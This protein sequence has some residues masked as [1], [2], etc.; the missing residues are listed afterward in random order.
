[1]LRA[2]GSIEQL[3]I[4]TVALVGAD[5]EAMARAIAKAS[6][7][8][9]QAI[10]TY[11]A[12]GIIQ[13]DDDETLHRKVVDSMLPVIIEALDTRGDA[14]VTDDAS[15][16]T[17][18][19][20]REDVVFSGDLDQV[21]D[22]FGDQGW[23]DGLPVVP[24]TIDRVRRFLAHT[25]RDA[26]EVLGILLP[27]HREATVWNVAVNGVMAGCRPEYLPVLIAIAEGIADPVFHLQDAGSTPGWEP[28][29]TVSGPIVEE[30]EFNYRQ[31]AMRVGRQANSSIGRFLRLYMRNVAGFRIP[32]GVTDGAAIGTTFNV[33]L[34]ES[35]VVA[36]E[37]GWPST[38]EE[39]GYGKDES[40]V[41]LQSVRS[42]TPPIYSMGITPAEHMEA[43][44]EAA[45][46][47]L[48]TSVHRAYVCGKQYPTILMNPA[49]AE[50][51]VKA[52]VGRQ[53]I[54]EY[55]AEHCWIPVHVAET[56]GQRVGRSPNAPTCLESAQQVGIDPE[57]RDGELS[58][59]LFIDPEAILVVA[60]GN[61]GR[62]QSRM[63]FDNAP[64]GGR[65]I[66]R[67][68]S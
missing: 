46:G 40:V 28:L 62:N 45:T 43:L 15:V 63:Y 13:T 33:V 59:P 35:D 61:P 50:V 55:L 64:Q 5:F 2:C 47:S 58:L 67:I 25:D 52:G 57:M 12:P 30:L 8:P 21:M 17:P 11:P 56:W 18:R 54:R 38:R 29:I 51:F 4:P 9:R 60:G 6:P 24:P 68:G 48:R 37:V 20:G 49:V 10:A 34:A 41:M 53:Y 23:T 66:R 36:A 19:I 26:E 31:G 65:V 22:H 27:E 44:A 3:G 7:G 16:P 14:V 1:M 39:L 32:P 42:I